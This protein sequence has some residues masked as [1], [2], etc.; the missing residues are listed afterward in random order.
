MASIRSVLSHVKI[1]TAE[2]KRKCHR[3]PKHHEI[4][5]DERC[6]TVDIRDIPDCPFPMEPEVR[7]LKYLLESLV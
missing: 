6:L 4:P 5:K 2:R 3:N 7:K 1:E